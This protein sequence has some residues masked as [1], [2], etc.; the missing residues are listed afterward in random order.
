M[1][2]SM[3]FLGRF[4]LLPNSDRDLLVGEVSNFL[5][6]VCDFLVREIY[7]FGVDEFFP[8]FRFH[9]PDCSIS[10]SQRFGG[11][12]YYRFTAKR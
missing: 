1:M 3:R 7:I 9:D 12:G 10:S 6:E 2:I 11:L 5:A 4:I 8:E